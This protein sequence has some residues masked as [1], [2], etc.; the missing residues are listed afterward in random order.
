MRLAQLSALLQGEPSEAGLP[1]GKARMLSPREGSPAKLTSIKGGQQ[2][3]L[4]LA[5]TTLLPPSIT[6]SLP[7][8]WSGRSSHAT[9]PRGLAC[10]GK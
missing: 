7:R 8:R 5:S 6:T 4:R 3:A 10:D 1:Q 9:L 2:H